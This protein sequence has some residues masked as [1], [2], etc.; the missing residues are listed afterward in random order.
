MKRKGFTLVELLA[1]IVILAVISLIATPMILG[2]IDT[3]KEGAAKSSAQGYLD[4]L[5]LYI[6][7]A[8]LN[9]KRVLEPNKQYNLTDTTVIGEKAYPEINSLV[10]I[11]GDGPTGYD[12]YIKFDS[13]YKVIEGKL[14]LNE[15]VVTIQDGKYIVSKVGVI[16]EPINMSLNITDQS[17]ERGSTT[18]IKTIFE[19]LNTSNQKVIYKSSDTNIVSVDEYG[20]IKTLQNGNATI[21]VT[22]MANKDITKSINIKVISPENIESICITKEDKETY[23]GETNQLIATILPSDA[24][25]N[26]LTWTSSNETVAIVDNA[27]L[28]TGVGVGTATI[29]ATSTNGKTASIE[30]KVEAKKLCRRA[31]ILHTEECEQTDSTY[32]CSGAGYT[33]S[34]KGT[35]ITYGS[36]G[37]SGIL[38]S[39][40]AFDCDINGDGVYNETTERFYYVSDLYNTTSKTFDDNYAVL[41]YYNNTTGGVL[42]NSSLSLEAYDLSGNNYNG[43]ITARNSLPN[44]NQWPNISLSDVTR[45][46]LTEIGETLIEEFSYEKYAA[47]LLTVEEVKKACNI[48]TIGSWTTGELDDCNYLIDNTQYSSSSRGTNGFWLENP[49]HSAGK[50][51]W[52][53]SSSQR[54]LNAVLVSYE[55][56]DGFG[57]RPVIEVLK[58][59]ISY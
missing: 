28:V 52:N 3:A 7:T 10:E 35:N 11:K 1:V 42:D 8:E 57:V 56:D 37:T 16:V 2:V 27:G 49:Y 20:N 4:A 21:T 59:D 29:T 31:T 30:I 5:E 23:I 26:A 17:M 55:G 48:T 6:S 9:N 47:R 54:L 40:D 41:I 51:A 12:D 22:S 32:Y 58:S 50:F 44:V 36:L 46:I 53:V 38:K 24:T 43:P 34:N 39:G 45:T 18:K 15:Y 14:T 19:P 13:N 25:S 33:S